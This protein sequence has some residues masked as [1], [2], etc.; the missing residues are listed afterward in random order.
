MRIYL[1]AILF[2]ICTFGTFGQTAAEKIYGTEREF[3]K[4]VAE[5]GINAAFVE[6][7]TP[8]AVMFFPDV[9]NAHAEW[10]S[11]QPSSAALTWNPL[12]IDVSANE[13]LGYSVGNSIYRPKG[14][15][16]PIRNAGHYLSIWLRRAD[17]T[18]RAVLDVG[19]KHS[20]PKVSIKD[21]KRPSMSGDENSQKISAAD[22]SSGFYQN[23][24]LGTAK[25]YSNYLA[26]SSILMRDGIEPVHGKRAI[27]EF[28]KKQAGVLSFTKRKSFMEAIDLAYVNSGYIISDNTG[29]EI[30]RGNFVHV[31]KF[32]SG[33][34]Q[35]VADVQ[36]PTTKAIK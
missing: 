34:W 12:L 9:R 25:T 18:Y 36:I 23:V 19:V 11:R 31:W 35:I 13:I 28:L 4:M 16:D 30:E 27:V 3:E 26:D 2:F 14:K 22:S 29:R 7:T 1:L 17:G 24:S 10:K 8:D 32:I 33:R 15:D 20:P 21:W 6:F 5:K